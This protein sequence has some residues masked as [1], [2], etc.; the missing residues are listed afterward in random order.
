MLYCFCMSLLTTVLIYIFFYLL[1]TFWN[2]I[3]NHVHVFLK[4]WDIV[5]TNDMPKSQSLINSVL[6]LTCSFPESQF[7]NVSSADSEK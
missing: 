4:S 7:N 1:K 3:Y 5:A 2:K 6:E